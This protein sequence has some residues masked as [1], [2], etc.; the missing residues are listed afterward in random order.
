VKPCLKYAHSGD[1]DDVPVIA[2]E[3]GSRV[4]ADIL[5]WGI[6]G[7]AIGGAHFV[8]HTTT[9][10]DQKISVFAAGQHPSS[11]WLPQRLGLGQAMQSHADAN[12]GPRPVILQRPFR[13]R[14]IPAL[15]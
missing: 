5:W 1:I 9:W 2:L 6:D 10:A 7:V 11:R 3:I 8:S 12:G 4:R 14:P 15:S 13:Y